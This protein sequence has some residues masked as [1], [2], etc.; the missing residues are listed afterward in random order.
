MLERMGRDRQT[1]HWHA[2]SEGKEITDDELRIA[3]GI[4][5]RT[6]E[7][8]SG[9]VREGGGK[10][11]PVAKLSTMMVDLSIQHNRHDPLL[12][13]IPTNLSAKSE[14]YQPE[15]KTPSASTT[16]A[17]TAHQESPKA[18]QAVSNTE[19][20]SSLVQGC[21]RLLRRVVSEIRDRVRIG[22]LRVLTAGGIVESP[23]AVQAV[24][25]TEA[26]SS[27]VQACRR[28]LPRFIS[29]I[30]DHGRIH[31]SRVLTAIGIVVLA[32]LGF[33]SV[34]EWRVHHSD[35]VKHRPQILPAMQ[36]PDKPLVSTTSTANTS[37]NAHVVA[38]GKSKSHRG[39]GDYVAK[40]T[41]VYYGKNGK[42]NQ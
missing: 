29:G 31:D 42:P 17:I 24:H 19:T 13:D 41:Y 25:N 21:G 30:R 11:N 7:S 18:V 12:G 22:D 39:Q 1:S 32:L 40:D 37:N 33:G 36:P 2:Q 20:H 6:I 10:T 28:L 15:P 14:C 23:K 16:V 26:H 38:Q 5:R 3:L 8:K 4:L 9:Y 34:H 35:S 27:L